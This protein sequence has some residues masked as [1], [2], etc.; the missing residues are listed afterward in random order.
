MTPEEFDRILQ[1]TLADR[2]LTQGER[3]ALTEVLKD[4]EP[5]EQKLAHYRHQAFD[6]ARA[7]LSDPQAATVLGWLEDVVKALW[8]RPDADEDVAEAYFSPQ[9]NCAGRIARLLETAQR[10]AD[11]CVFTITDDRITNAVLAAHRR[12]VA[13]RIISDR[14]KADDLG[15]DIARLRAAGVPVRV[16]R[17]EYHMHH[18]FAIFDGRRLLNGS[19]NWTRSASAN[20]CENFMVTSDRRLIAAFGKAFEQIWE[21]LGA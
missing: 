21:Q 13:V 15:S 1:Q 9:D 6:A 18:K 10:Q 4:V 19:Y 20:N 16:D 2:R 12:G 7:A 11:I 5:D 8:P 17:S 14:E 3:R